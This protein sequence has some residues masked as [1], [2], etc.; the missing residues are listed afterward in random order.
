MSDSF[1][2]GPGNRVDHPD[3]MLILL[4]NESFAVDALAF[5]KAYYPTMFEAF[6]TEALTPSSLFLIWAKLAQSFTFPL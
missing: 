1:L 4:N 6:N 5:P 3:D 2:C